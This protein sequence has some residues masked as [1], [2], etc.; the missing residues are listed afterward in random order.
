MRSNFDVIVGMLWEK[1]LSII[2]TGS[3]N[4][5]MGDSTSSIEILTKED[6]KKAISEYENL[7]RGS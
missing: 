1:H 4:G 2:T 6:F 7:R 3:D 5:P